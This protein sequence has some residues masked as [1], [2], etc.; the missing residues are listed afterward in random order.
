MNAILFNNAKFDC[1][2]VTKETAKKN[3]IQH[4]Y[5]HNQSYTM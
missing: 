1:T 4:Y 5:D 3:G 2:K